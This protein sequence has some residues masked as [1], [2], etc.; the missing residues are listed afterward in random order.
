MQ[1]TFAN[2]T[3]FNGDL[4]KWSTTNV[5][6]L[7]AMFYGSKAYKMMDIYYWTIPANASKKSMLCGATGLNPFATPAW[8]TD[9]T[10]CNSGFV[11]ASEFD[12]NNATAAPMMNVTMNA[13]APTA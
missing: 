12:H 1:Y 10:S 4:G 13:T 3:V 8:R 5:K 2:T 11:F 7:D 9:D 6:K